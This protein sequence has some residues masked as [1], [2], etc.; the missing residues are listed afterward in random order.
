MRFIPVQVLIIS[1]CL[2][3]TGRLGAREEAG[4]VVARAIEA[5]GGEAVLSKVRAIHARIKGTYWPNQEAPFT[6]ELFSQLPDHSKVVMR[7]RIQGNSMTMIEMLSGNKAWS[8]EGG[9]LR[10]VDKN[11][12]DRMKESAYVEHVES[13]W[14]LLKG[15]TFKL[16]R[17]DE[18]RIEGRPAVGVKV[19]SAGHQD[20]RL[21]FDKASGLL[22]K[23]E[24]KVLWAKPGLEP[25]KNRETLSTTY[26]S[27][28]RQVFSAAAEEQILKTHKVATDN[29][30][31][32]EFVRKRTLSDAKRE[33]IGSLIRK[34]GDAEFE[35][36]EKARTE[37]IKHGEAARPLVT[38]R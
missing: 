12:L 33:Q 25:G 7:I 35:T 16:T 19:S 20:V 13:L 32:L 2:E 24:R 1:I 18:I 11:E 36:R 37:L 29:P 23:V 30:A 9:N 10:E 28:Y 31:L 3:L 34:L 8:G 4:A 26:L 21:F 14:P 22:S 27:D 38:A 6:A 15:D 5:Q 17:L